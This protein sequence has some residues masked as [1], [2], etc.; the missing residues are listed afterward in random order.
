MGLRGVFE[1]PGARPAARRAEGAICLRAAAGAGLPDARVRPMRGSARASR[2]RGLEGAPEARGAGLADPSE[3]RG[4]VA[5]GCRE[6]RR[7]GAPRIAP[8]GRALS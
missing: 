4:R 5:A 6:A 1:P 7:R 3:V 2:A 8:E